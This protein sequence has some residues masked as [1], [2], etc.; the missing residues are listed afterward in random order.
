MSSN[1]NTGETGTFSCKTCGKTA[2]ESGHLCTP[3]VPEKAVVCDYCGD[4]ASDPRHVCAPKVSALKYS[5]GS[6]GRVAVSKDDLCSA[7]K[8]PG[9]KEDAG[10]SGGCCGGGCS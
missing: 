2:P 1:D 6:C 3:V 8:I 4:T 10:E 9:V 5:C 7:E